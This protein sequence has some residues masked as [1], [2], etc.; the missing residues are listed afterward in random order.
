[1]ADNRGIAGSGIYAARIGRRDMAQRETRWLQAKRS[2]LG[3]VIASSGWVARRR[4]F[5]RWS[6]SSSLGRGGFEYACLKSVDDT[7][8]TMTLATSVIADKKRFVREG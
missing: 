3:S 8:E 1:M 6:G 5:G 7:A 4:P 2:R